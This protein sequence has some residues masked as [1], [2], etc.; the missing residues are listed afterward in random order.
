[1]RTTVDHVTSRA[2]GFPT[3]ATWPGLAVKAERELAT[4]PRSAFPPMRES[5]PSGRL[6]LPDIV[7]GRLSLP[8]LARPAVS[9]LPAMAMSVARIAGDRLPVFEAMGR[10]FMVKTLKN[11]ADLP[12][13]DRLMKVE[14]GGLATLLD[15]NDVIDLMDDCEL[16][17]ARRSWAS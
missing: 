8:V 1:M 3:E 16:R 2:V 9:P 10:R 4:V 13:S 15:D 17:V 12:P 14:A 11:M 7:R 5:V 6:P